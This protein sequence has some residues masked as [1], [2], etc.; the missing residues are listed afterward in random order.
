MSSVYGRYTCCPHTI[1]CNPMSPLTCSSCRH[2]A[3]AAAHKKIISHTFRQHLKILAKFIFNFGCYLTTRVLVRKD[4][5]CKKFQQNLGAE[6][7]SQCASVE[8]PHGSRQ[9]YLHINIKHQ[10]TAALYIIIMYI[11][12]SLPMGSR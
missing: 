3:P 2:K 7:A 10:L 6:T 5:F 11:Y 4:I 8:T 1:T 9:P 12:R